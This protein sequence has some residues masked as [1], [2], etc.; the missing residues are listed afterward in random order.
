[1]HMTTGREYLRVSLDKSGRSRSTEE[2]HTANVDQVVVELDWTLGDPYIDTDRSASRYARKAR[3]GF[4]R[5]IADLKA[6]QFG[7]DCLILWES[8]RGSRKVSEWLELLELCEESSILIY[9]TT[10]GR[11]YDPSNPRDR[12][13][14]LEDAVDSEYESA[15]TSTRLKRAQAANA[16]AGMPHGRTPFGYQRTYDQKTGRFVSQ[17]RNPDEAPLVVEL[18]DRLRRGHTFK[19]IARDWEARG[20]VGR[21]GK[22]FKDGSLRQM[23]LNPCYDGKRLYLPGEFTGARFSNERAELIDAQWPALVDHATFAAVQRMLK[24]PERRTFRSGKAAHLLSLIVRCD[25]CSGWM[26]ALQGRYRCAAKGCASIQEDD[27]D[28]LVESVLLAYLARPDVYESV[29]DDGSEDSALATVRH[30][31]EEARGE[32]EDLRA[33]LDRGAISVKT[34][35]RAEPA[36][37]ARVEG[38][39][40]RES[41]LSTPSV[42]RGLIAPGKDVEAR[43]KAAELPTRR[44]VARILLSA[45]LLGEVR[46][47]HG[48]RGHRIPAIERVE[49]RRAE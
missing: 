18:F 27:L 40:A 36:L 11:Q 45:D 42:L 48:V 23:V 25:V 35:V 7:A 10:H 4:D 49:W 22:P 32:L 3:E 5:L 21:S 37:I 31:L 41:D 43:W 19:G 38:L 30:D 12:K 17:D 16:A 28:D 47:K 46:V 2:Q 29:T 33:A 1:M 8:S 13:S 15:K 6:G 44:E 26:T 14:L 34:A 39:E 9:V 20:I 24:A